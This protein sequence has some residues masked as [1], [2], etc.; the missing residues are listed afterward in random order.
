MNCFQH[1]FKII[2]ELPF[3]I[4]IRQTHL[5][6]AFVLSAPHGTDSTKLL[7]FKSQMIQFL[8]LFLF[9]YADGYTAKGTD[10]ESS[11]TISVLSDLL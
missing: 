1:N 4:N 3:C 6:H 9:D 8:F 5:S 7:S 2:W 11:V 10:F